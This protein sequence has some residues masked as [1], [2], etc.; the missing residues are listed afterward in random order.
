MQLALRHVL[1]VLCNSVCERQQSTT[2]AGYNLTHS[3]SAAYYNFSHRLLPKRPRL[4]KEG[5]HCGTAAPLD[6]STLKIRLVPR[7]PS[8]SRDNPLFPKSCTRLARS[9]AWK[10]ARYRRKGGKGTCTVARVAVSGKC[11]RPL[12]SGRSSGVDEG[13]TSK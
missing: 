10:S 4:A 2:L 8:V 7:Q 12:Q 1:T 11:G 13:I 6:F 5:D 3:E 9:P